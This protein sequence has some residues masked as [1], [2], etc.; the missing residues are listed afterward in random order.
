MNNQLY[1]CKNRTLDCMYCELAEPHEQLPNHAIIVCDDRK[2]VRIEDDPYRNSPNVGSSAASD[3]NIPLGN[4]GMG[5]K[6]L[7][8]PAETYTL[9]GKDSS[10]PS[11]RD[12]LEKSLNIPKYDM[13]TLD[14]KSLRESLSDKKQEKII[15]DQLMK[16]TYSSKELMY[17]KEMILFYIEQNNALEADVSVYTNI[18]SVI[19]KSIH[20][21]EMI[22]LPA[23]I[24]K[25][26]NCENCDVSREA[27]YYPEGPC[28]V[29]GC[30]VVHDSFTGWR[31]P[32]VVNSDDDITI[33]VLSKEEIERLINETME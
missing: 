18:I 29:R 13:S 4:S 32:I 30:K 20:V 33:T 24:E 16:I 11:R 14:S 26:K 22:G 23:A 12:C 19:Q 21:K 3:T 8:Y 27:Q 1:I 2:C 15:I 17:L 10:F 5:S 28:E 6:V 25:L 9:I 31:N 7:G